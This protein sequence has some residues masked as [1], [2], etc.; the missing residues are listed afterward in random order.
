MKK[1]LVGLVSMLLML[2]IAGCSGGGDTTDDTA[3]NDTTEE[4]ASKEP[5]S[6][7]DLDGTM[8]QS[9]IVYMT[10]TKRVTE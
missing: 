7:G 9:A 1:L 3:A 6:E 2:C 10:P 5:A 8:Y 4:S